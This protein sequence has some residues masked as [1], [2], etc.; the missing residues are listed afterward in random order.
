MSIF[1]K[2]YHGSGLKCGGPAMCRD[3]RE[4]IEKGIP[5]DNPATTI[6]GSMGDIPPEFDKIFQDNF[7]DLLVKDEDEET[8]DNS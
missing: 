8:T 6:L 7:W 3:C 4:R 2:K 5:M 1:P